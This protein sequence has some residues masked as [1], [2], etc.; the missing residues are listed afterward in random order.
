MNQKFT[1]SHTF[2][3]TRGKEI[4]NT[5]ETNDF[6]L[7]DICERFTEFLRG[8]GFHLERIEVVKEKENYES[9]F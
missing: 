1:F 3:D 6:L 7:E 4:N 8:C 2:K 5:L 9:K